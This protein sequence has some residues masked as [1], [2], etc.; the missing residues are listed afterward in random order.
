REAGRLRDLLR[1]LAPREGTASPAAALRR[2]LAVG[3]C[4]LA[5]AGEHP[6]VEQEVVLQQIS[7][8][9]PDSFGGRAD[10]GKLAGT[11]LGQFGAFYKKSWRVNDWIWGRLDGAT[12]MVQAVLDP[13]RLL[14][15]GLSPQEAYRRLRAVAVG[16][17]F[18]D[19]LAARFDGDRERIERELA[20][21]GAGTDGAVPAEPDGSAAVEPE[22]PAPCP[23][24]TATVL[25]V[26]R[27]LHAE[28]LDEELDGLAEAVREDFDAGAG[29]GPEARR[30]LE[31]W[32]GRPE[33]PS[34]DFLLAAFSRAEIGEEEFADEMRTP[35]FLHTAGRAGAV[36]AA[37][38]ASA[39]GRRSARRAWWSCRGRWPARSG[40]R[41]RHG[42]G[43]AGGRPRACC[44]GCA[45][46]ASRPAGPVG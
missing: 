37:V 31:A 36:G 24:L 7:A 9:T 16:G 38:I 30:F 28:I 13:G 18:A 21:L 20:F 17:R 27:R 1:E 43:P 40:R 8:R 22:G 6:E 14:Q 3:V 29:Q 41:S 32:Q 19:E 46:T 10:P 44:G 2:M 45:S 11:K 42:S 25:A 35:L 5:V 23:E 39:L 26:A 15:L 34:M 4:R 12:R 33:R